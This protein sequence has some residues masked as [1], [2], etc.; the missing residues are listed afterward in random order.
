M[1]REFFTSKKP[2]LLMSDIVSPKKEPV[3]DRPAANKEKK[4]K[5]SRPKRRLVI[6]FL[7]ILIFLGA[8]YIALK[9]LPRVEI[10]ISLQKYPLNFNQTV[11]AGILG[12]TKLPAEL[13]TE[14]RNLQMNFPATGKQNIQTKAQGKIIIYNS[15]S[16]DAQNLVAGTRFLTP[17][18]KIFRLVKNITVPGAKIQEGKIIVS[19]IETDVVADQPGPEYNIEPVA[20]FTIPGLKGSPKYEGFYGQS[21]K[22]MAGG[23]VGE[24]AV[25]TDKD[26]ADAKVKIKQALETNL[27]TII[28]SQFPQELKILDG[29]SEFKIL[30]EEVKKE[31]DKD[32]N[33]GIFSEA[34]MKLIA[35]REKDLKDMLINQLKPQLTAGDYEIENFSLNYGVSRSDFEKGLMSFP[36]NGQIVFQNKIDLEGLRQQAKGQNEQ[37]LKSLVFK[38]PG[39]GKAQLSFWPR[40]VKTAPNNIN[41]I[42]VII[43]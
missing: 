38:L 4:L 31:T 12:G 23:F 7:L 22:P 10:K 27:K 18:N 11:E 19:N 16:S 28:F 40:Y 41:K 6:L 2:Q 9:V 1:P 39:L 15:Y 30:R 42:K 34:Q 26:I 37:A 17:D 8:G 14:K 33:F 24:A 29:A 21:T 3:S 43:Q 13:F 35:F 5:K 36:I 25:P 32:N 20:K